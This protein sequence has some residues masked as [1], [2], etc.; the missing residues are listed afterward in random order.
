MI[1]MDADASAA[2]LKG[3][4]G[5]ARNAVRAA[6]V[7]HTQRLFEAVAAK[8]PPGIAANLR[9][10]VSDDGD[11]VAGGISVDPS[12]AYARIREFG[13]RILVPET[14]PKTTKALA[15]HYEGKLVFAKHARAHGVDIPAQPYLRPALAEITPTF[16]SA[17]Q[18]AI[19]GLL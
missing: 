16:R 1:A 11:G 13:G 6:A 18:D 5:A 17:L 15:F 8:V 2:M 19:T 10:S 4:A 7:D 9:Q 3:L 14:A 12:L